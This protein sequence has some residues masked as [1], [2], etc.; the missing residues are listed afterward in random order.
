[1]LESCSSSTVIFA[2]PNG[3][4]LYSLASARG[5]LTDLDNIFSREETFTQVRG[6]K[7]DEF[8]RRGQGLTKRASFHLLLSSSEKEEL[9]HQMSSADSL[10]QCQFKKKTEKQGRVDVGQ[11]FERKLMMT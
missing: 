4:F 6:V 11:D 10:G 7:G 3:P 2:F 1:M 8:E 9:G 5:P